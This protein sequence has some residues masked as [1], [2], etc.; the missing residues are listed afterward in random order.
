MSNRRLLEI[1]LL[2]IMVY[3][4]IWLWNDYVASL[5]SVLVV[6]IC[7]GVFIVALIAELI[8]KS[9]VP[10]SYFLFMIGSILIPLIVGFVF[11]SLMGGDLDWLQ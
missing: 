6:A 8:E 10:K 3:L 2:Q 1:F 5:V 11:I 7:A 9:K 4:V